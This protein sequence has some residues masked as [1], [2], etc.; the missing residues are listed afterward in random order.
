MTRRSVPIIV[1]ALLGAVLAAPA[2]PV[3]GARAGDAASLAS[4]GIQAVSAGGSTTCAIRADG[5]LACWGRDDFGQANP[6]AG[7][8][9]AVSIGGLYACAVRTDGTLACWG[10]DEFGQASP[11]AGTFV[12]VSAGM[13]HAC[14]IG[15]DG[16]LSCWGS[17][18]YGEASPPDGVFT[19][20]TAGGR[21]SCAIRADDVLTCW[22]AD[23]Y[24]GLPVSVV[25]A[26]SAGA[27][28]T[29][30]IKTDGTLACWGDNTDGQASPPEGTFTAVDAA[31]AYTCGIRTDATLACW[32]Y[33]EDGRAS[34][35]PGT[36]TALSAGSTHACAIATDGALACW[37]SNLAGQTTPR[38]TASI[39]ALPTWVAT[40]AVT[41]R[42]SAKAAL[43]PV[44]TYAVRYR[45]AKWNGGFG[46]VATW[47]PA[48]PATTAVH[49]AAPGYT[50][51]FSTR[52]TDADDQVSAWTPETCTAVPLDD[53]ALARS[54]RWALKTGSA[55]YASTYV[56]SSTQGAK[57]VRK[58]VAARRIAILATTCPTCGKV[59]VYWNSTLLKT[60]SLRSAT[61]VTRKLIAVTTFPSARTGTLTIKVKTTGSRVI[62]DGV[63]IRRD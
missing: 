48:T 18:D 25:S 43:A 55:Y 51:C 59:S 60:I 10:D 17:N 41:V 11:P 23:A 63:A 39:T 22:G 40:T 47:L 38:P 15:T 8:F 6:P 14:A 27:W 21:H 56:R 46:P 50:Y 12:A 31:G 19:A 4:A 42:W 28:H 24:Q 58:G 32:G 35:P 49:A 26:V 20:V 52:A 54:G 3:D 7:S 61:T 30:A 13:E 29:C 5:T 62:I 9:S 37:G 53:R 1:L 2:G 57:L 34:P 36:Y 33:D 45:R 44:A 16:T